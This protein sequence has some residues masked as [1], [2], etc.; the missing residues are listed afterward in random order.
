MYD[1]LMMSGVNPQ[2]HKQPTNTTTMVMAPLAHT[3][4]WIQ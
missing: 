4:M 1:E 3:V 2:Q